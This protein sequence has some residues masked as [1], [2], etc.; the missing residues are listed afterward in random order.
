M[1]RG[2]PIIRLIHCRVCGELVP[3][4]RWRF[5]SAACSKLFYSG[6]L[7][8][9]CAC[10]KPTKPGDPLCRVCKREMRAALGL[11]GAA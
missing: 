2:K 6:N 11:R 7:T 10:G 1:M 9:I 3:P 5:C 8:T 4:G